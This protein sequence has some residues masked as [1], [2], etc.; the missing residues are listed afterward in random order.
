[1]TLLEAIGEIKKEEANFIG[2]ANSEKLA[3]N[4]VK[5]AND[6]GTAIGLLIALQILDD[7]Q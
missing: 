2:Y 6:R 7:V 1:M 4:I 5:E 3:G